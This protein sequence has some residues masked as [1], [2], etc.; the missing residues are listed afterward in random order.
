MSRHATICMSSGAAYLHELHGP[1]LKVPLLHQRD[2]LRSPPEDLDKA[3]H[4]PAFVRLHRLTG[5]TKVPNVQVFI[6][7]Q[8]ILLAI[9]REAAIC[10]RARLAAF[11]AEMHGGGSWDCW[12][13]PTGSHIIE[14]D[15]I[16]R[17]YEFCRKN[18]LERPAVTP[19]AGHFE[20][21]Q[22]DSPGL[23]SESR[24]PSHFHRCS[25]EHWCAILRYSKAG[26]ALVQPTREEILPADADRCDFS[27]VRHTRN[28]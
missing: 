16:S 26:N 27:F 1:N 13:Q 10:Q 18:V 6:D 15:L 14:R 19:L 3:A 21:T 28:R 8:G 4:R 12:S 5:F 20:C 24:D 9:R 7:C 25:R 22:R 23:E 17:R 2:L 11:V